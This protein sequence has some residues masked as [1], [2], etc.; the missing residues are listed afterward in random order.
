MGDLVH[1][2]YGIWIPVCP[3]EILNPWDSAIE[4]IHITKN[5][6]CSCNHWVPV[7]VRVREI[8]GASFSV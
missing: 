4:H 6:Q 8:L 2:K 5:L 7:V 3:H 1:D